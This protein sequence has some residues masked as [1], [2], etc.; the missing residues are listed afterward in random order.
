MNSKWINEAEYNLSQQKVNKILPAVVVAVPAAVVEARD[1][2]V[3]K[4]FFK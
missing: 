2:P 4:H 3:P 1:A